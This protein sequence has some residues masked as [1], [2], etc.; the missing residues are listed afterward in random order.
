VCRNTRMS[1]TRAQGQR[2]AFHEIGQPATVKKR[3]RSPPL[4]QI[5][6]QGNQKDVEALSG[7]AAAAARQPAA[8]P[9]GRSLSRTDDSDDA[10]EDLAAEGNASDSSSAGN[11]SERV[12]AAANKVSC[13]SPRTLLESVA[14]RRLVAFCLDLA[15][16]LICPACSAIMA[17][18]LCTSQGTQCATLHACELRRRG[19]KPAAAIST[20]PCCAAQRLPL[21]RMTER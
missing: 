13:Y 20:S 16:Q 17:S 19:L 21:G 14:F 15:R 3:R 9:V 6:S 18:P 2:R 10:E 11:S 8:P 5:E 4:A 7:A 1:G 12:G